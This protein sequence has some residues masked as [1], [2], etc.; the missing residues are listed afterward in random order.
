MTGRQPFSDL[1]REFSPERW[2][3]VAA[4]AARLSETM[5]LEELR[6]ARGR[7]Q[8]EVAGALAVGQPAVAKLAKRAGMHVSNLRRF[9]EALGGQLEISARFPDAVAQLADVGDDNPEWTAEDFRRTRPALEVIG[10]VFGAE[11]AAALPR[12][13]GRPSKPGG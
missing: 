11:A 13:R 3:R 8:E 10:E 6:K 7:S 1:T 2:A 9:V 5:T 12:R 4:K